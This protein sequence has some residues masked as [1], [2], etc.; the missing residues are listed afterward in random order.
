MSFAH[1]RPFRDPR[2]EPYTPGPSHATAVRALPNGTI[3]LSVDDDL[4]TTIEVAATT[5]GRVSLR[6]F[7]VDDE[8]TVT[9]P[10]FT[11]SALVDVLR[12]ITHADEATLMPGAR[13]FPRAES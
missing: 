11:A 13:N 1:R 6:V 8:V 10:A 7:T 5:P 2:P 3:R 9:V 12:A 4:A